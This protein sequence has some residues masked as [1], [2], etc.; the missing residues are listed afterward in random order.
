MHGCKCVQVNFSPS[1]NNSTGISTPQLFYFLFSILKDQELFI[2]NC[3]TNQL[4]L[5][6]WLTIQMIANFFE[7]WYSL[8]N[9]YACIGWRIFP[10]EYCY[11]SKNNQI[12]TLC[13]MLPLRKHNAVFSEIDFPASNPFYLYILSILI[14]NTAAFNIFYELWVMNPWVWRPYSCNHSIWRNCKQ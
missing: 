4:N 14:S 7:F 9:L 13:I 8:S 10:I 12:G 1:S 6:C 11:W 3:K 2:S 5:Y